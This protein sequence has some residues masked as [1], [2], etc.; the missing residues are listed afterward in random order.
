VPRV[1]EAHEEQGPE[2]GGQLDH[3]H[4]GRDEVPLFWFGEPVTTILKLEVSYEGKK[5]KL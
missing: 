4:A 5:S 3:R 2:R 1:E